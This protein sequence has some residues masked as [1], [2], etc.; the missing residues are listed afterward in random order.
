VSTATVS[1]REILTE[2]ADK[3]CL[4]LHQN[5]NH[6]VPRDAWKALMCPPWGSLWPNHGFQLVGPDEQLLGVYVAV[7]SARDDGRPIVCN[8]AA[9]CVLEEYRQQ[10]ARLVRALIRQTGC[11]FTDLSPSGNVPAMNLRLGFS[12]LDTGTRLVVNTPS[13]NRGVSV[14]DDPQVLQQR[15]VARDALVYRDHRRAAAA[16][17][18]IV[19]QGDDYAYLM[20]RRDRRKRLPVFASP[21][22][23]GGSASVLEATWPALGRHLLRKGLVATLAERR[24]LGFDPSGLGRE[25][26][27]PRVK[28]HKGQPQNEV[29]YLYSELALIEW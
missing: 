29:D 16:R 25:L 18:A 10:S 26:A 4:F 11:V 7:Y 28:M 24:V 5:L 14:T 22:F 27:R 9:F 15:L 1:I 13:L 12:E 21:I 19:L 20:Y 6:R 23:A 2:D 3:V 17:H 8:L